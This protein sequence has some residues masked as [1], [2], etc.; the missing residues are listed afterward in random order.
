ME[1]SLP[2]ELVLLRKTVKGFV[3]T[4]LRPLEKGIE[5]AG[6]VDSEVLR[7]LRRRAVQ[8]GIY[9]H[10]LPAEVGGGGLTMLGQVVVAEELG[11]TT[12]A[13]SRTAGYL[14]ALL[15]YTRPDQREWFLS[16]LLSGEKFVTY[17]VTESD[18]GSDV[19][20][21]KTRAKRVDGGW[22]LNGGKCFVS[23]VDIADW[24]IVVAVTES[25]APLSGRFTLFIVDKTNPGFHFMRNIRKLGWR[26]A[27]FCQFSLDDCGVPDHCIIGEVN[28]G[29]ELI[30]LAINLTRIHL[31]GIYVGMGDEL[32]DLGRDYAK[33]R[34]TFGK[35]LADH[36]AIQFMLADIDC[37]LEASR[38][39]VYAAADAVDNNRSDMRIAASRAKVFASEMAF[40]TADRVLQIYGA[41]GISCDYPIERMFRDSRAFRIGE[42]TSEIQRI[43]IARHLLR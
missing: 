43:Q 3:D 10:N 30:M 8:L 35:R 1:F 17:A 23:N 31:G 12:I 27:E 19:G 37:E 21:I 11:R 13:L 9:A 29:F 6:K 22:V 28:G 2:E 38:L 33:Q 24:V 32:R 40:R 25:A 18:V 15:A 42:G 41:A 26:G 39:L 20:A 14:P 7:S 4:Q 16:P 5:E 36:Q 34:K